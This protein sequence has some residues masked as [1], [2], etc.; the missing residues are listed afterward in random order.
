MV[1]VIDKQGESKVKELHLFSALLRG[2]LSTE[3]LH[4]LDTH[5]NWFVA[6]TLRFKVCPSHLSKNKLRLAGGVLKG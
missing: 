1:Y 6:A 4:E 3:E 2:L 5:S